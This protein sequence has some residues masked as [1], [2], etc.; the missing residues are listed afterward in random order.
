MVV[1]SANDDTLAKCTQVIIE[2]GRR[3][4]GKAYHNS[5]DPA[6]TSMKGL[7]P[8]TCVAEPPGIHLPHVAHA[9]DPYYEVVHAWRDCVEGNTP[10]TLYSFEEPQSHHSMKVVERAASN[11]ESV[12]G[13]EKKIVAMKK[14]LRMEE[15]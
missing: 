6:T 4:K 9:N 10:S 5:F 15:T 1:G 3:E 14:L 12:F 7:L 13:V 8:P 11:R 2:E